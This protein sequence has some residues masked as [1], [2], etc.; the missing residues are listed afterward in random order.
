MPYAESPPLPRPPRVAKGR[1][2]KLLI[3]LAL[4]PAFCFGA[5]I[6]LRV[7][8]LVWPFFVPT[9]GMAAAVAAGDHI[10]ME[11]VTFLSREP[12]R[13]D[14]VVFSGCY[15]VLGDNSASSLDSRFWGSVP[16]GNIIGRAAF[17]YWPARRVGGV[18]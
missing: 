12:R 8:G 18:E 4:V 9:A 5:L 7:S 1:R 10:M 3:V 13:G 6:V 17:C 11:G 15:F 2:A 16:R 14:I